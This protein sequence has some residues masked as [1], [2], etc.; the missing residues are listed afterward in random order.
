M[1]VFHTK[2]SKDFVVYIWKLGVKQ[3]FLLNKKSGFSIQALWFSFICSYHVTLMYIDVYI[4]GTFD[5]QLFLF[6]YQ[7]FYILSY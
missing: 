6:N 2:E 1:H 4:L 5:L 3:L 7:Y